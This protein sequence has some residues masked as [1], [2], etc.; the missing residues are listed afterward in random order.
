MKIFVRDYER[1]AF[2]GLALPCLVIVVRADAEP[3]L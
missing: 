2:V 3:L 1:V